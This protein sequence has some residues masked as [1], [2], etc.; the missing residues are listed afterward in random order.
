MIGAMLRFDEALFR[1]IGSFRPSWA[2]RSMKALTHL[3]DAPSWFAI[4]LVLLA[5][6]GAAAAEGRLLGTAAILATLVSQ[7]LKRVCL[8]PRPSTAGLVALIE[9]PDAF[10]FPSGHSAAAVAVA[11]ALAG[12]G[13]FL[14]PLALGL[15]AAVAVSRIYLGAHY[16][17]DVGAGALLGCGCGA[18]ARLIA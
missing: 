9:N 4:G 14:G 1:R 13:A 11:V 16:P 2:V 12:H 17:L 8:R 7:A 6:G 18:L 10:S 5:C 15:A 3:G